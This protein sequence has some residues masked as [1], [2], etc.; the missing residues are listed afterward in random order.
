MLNYDIVEAQNILPDLISKCI[1]GN[2]VFITKEGS[3]IVKLVACKKVRRKRVFGSA[4]GL[5]KMSKDFDQPLED[6]KDYKC[7]ISSYS[8]S[9]A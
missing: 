9:S 4:K 7:L 5:I 3:P 2:E 8:S 1:Y 6:F